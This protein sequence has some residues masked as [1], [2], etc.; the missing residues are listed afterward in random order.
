M[1]LRLAASLLFFCVASTAAAAPLR[2][3]VDPGHG[4]EREGAVGPGGTREKD[5]ALEISLRLARILRQLGHEVI[6]TRESD[7]SLGLAERTRLANE[8]EADLFVSIHANSAPSA[9]SRVQ[10]VETYFLSADAT[11]AQARALAS[12]ENAEEGPVEAPEDPLEFILADLARMKAHAES[13]RLAV[14]IHENLVRRT[15]ARDRGVRQA[16]FFVLS[17]ARM[18]AVLVEVGYLS[19][20][21]EERRL[22]SRENQEAIAR[23]IAE[24]IEA[25]GRRLMATASPKR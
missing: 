19:H 6:L 14:A 10:G 11:D 5:V 25:F 18:P 4:G 1:R 22:A 23:A 3:V 8:R 7:V 13:S 17:G 24:G 9:R 21:A 20:P 16:P 15:G 12:L 2:V